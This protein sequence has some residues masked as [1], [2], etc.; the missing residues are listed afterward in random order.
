MVDAAGNWT[1]TSSPL[2][3][4]IHSLTMKQTDLAGNV[5]VGFGWA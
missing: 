3:D 5:S 4:G 1:I 2:L